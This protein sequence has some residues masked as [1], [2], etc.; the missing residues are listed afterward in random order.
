MHKTKR[1]RSVIIAT[2]ALVLFVAASS[3]AQ[4]Q[5]EQTPAPKEDTQRTITE[6]ELAKAALAYLKISEINEGLQSSLQ[7]AESQEQRQKMQENANAMMVQGVENAGLTVER[8]NEIIQ[9]VQTS[10]ES[11]LQFQEKVKALSG[12]KQAPGKEE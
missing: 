12:K 1:I 2:A 6:E 11:W 3:S 4:Q 9:Y 10:T 5:Y 8:Y 7:S